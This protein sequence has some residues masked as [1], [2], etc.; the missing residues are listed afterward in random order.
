MLGFR[1][2][3]RGYEPV[4]AHG[5]WEALARFAEERPAAIALDSMMPVRDGMEGLRRVRAS[6]SGR[7]VPIIILSARRGEQ[8]I[9][10]AL[11]AGASDYI[12]KP[13]LP[14]E[15]FVRLQRLLGAGHPMRH[16]ICPRFLRET[17]GI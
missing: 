5:G 16:P 7:D 8:D 6:G 17:K 2:R 15:L 12:D 11:Q 14:E 3:A 13:F 1:L 4:I 10:Q 9:V